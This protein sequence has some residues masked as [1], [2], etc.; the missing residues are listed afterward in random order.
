MNGKNAQCVTCD[1]QLLHGL[2]PQWACF[3]A[4]AAQSQGDSQL[5]HVVASEKRGHAKASTAAAFESV[6][7]D[8]LKLR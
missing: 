4:F 6:N 7:R 3:R 2:D 1:S 5:M 8:L